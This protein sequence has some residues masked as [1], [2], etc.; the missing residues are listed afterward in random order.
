MKNN[1]RK[2]SIP[3]IEGEPFFQHLRS[4]KDE[5][6]HPLNC[7]WEITCRCNFKCVMCY[8]DC[9]NTPGDI[10]REL[11]TEEIFRIMDDMKEAGV[12]ELTLTGGE[13]M[14][15]PDF[16][17]IY[18][19]AVQNGFLT[20][21]FTNGSYINEAWIQLWT[22]FPPHGI[23]ISI[24]GATR[25]TFDQVTAMSGSHERVMKAV[26]LVINAGLPLMVKTTGLSLNEHEVLTIKEQM[27]KIPG[28][29]AKFNFNIRPQADGN[30]HPYQYQISDQ[31][32]EKIFESD[33]AFKK[34][35][36][37]LEAALE[38]CSSTCHEGKKQFHIDAYG[39]MQ[40]CSRNR[41]NSYDL[42]RGN[43]REGFYKNLPVF[44][45]PRKKPDGSCCSPA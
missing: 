2:T 30:E 19:R 29:H 42:R 31:R 20:T 26:Q 18:L 7:Q 22:D 34:A 41:V 44:F 10:A 36:Q 21:V 23:E 24:H 1:L 15:R 45:C 32:L 5:D 17:A 27:K 13:P 28:I 3:A 8:T 33:E 12:L 40:L 38:G 9:F 16:K 14:S 37:D 43:F 4:L 25:E 35:D 39:Q 11:S 6:R